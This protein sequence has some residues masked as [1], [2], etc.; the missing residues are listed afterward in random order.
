ML[1]PPETPPSW[2]C[3][4]KLP[5]N[6]LDAFTPLVYLTGLDLQT[7]PTHRSFWEVLN[8]KNATKDFQPSYVNVPID[9]KFREKKVKVV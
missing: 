6:L 5:P 8:L 4:F 9:H 7:N 1:K 3:D 2:Y